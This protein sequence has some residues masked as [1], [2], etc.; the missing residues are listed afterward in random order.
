MKITES[1]RKS[2]LV[3]Q[4]FNLFDSG[5]YQP[6]LE[7]FKIIDSIDSE[8]AF[9]PIRMAF[10]YT[11]LGNYAEAQGKLMEAI[12][13]NPDNLSLRAFLA[14][15]YLDQ[16]MVDKALETLNPLV[17]NGKPPKLVSDSYGLCL[18]RM[19]K[20]DEGYK[21]L[22]LHTA[23]IGY[24]GVASR[25]FSACELYLSEHPDISIEL[26][27]NLSDEISRNLSIKFKAKINDLLFG[28]KSLFIS[29]AEKNAREIL[30]LARQSVNLGEYSKARQY[31]EDLLK[32]K[33]NNDL[34]ALAAETLSGIKDYAGVIGVADSI[35]GY[36]NYREINTLKT[37]SLLR[38][39]DLKGAEALLG[40]SERIEISYLYGLLYLKQGLLH[41][42]RKKFEKVLGSMNINTG[43][44]LAGIRLKEA[45]RVYNLINDNRLYQ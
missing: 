39:G 16:G 25:V 34:L 3:R 17:S 38:L 14:T 41:S 2:I 43:M 29:G 13:L 7:K 35:D 8:D 15:N 20:I 18:L 21:A 44:D 31:I 40:N 9:S 19:G 4:A 10:C 23:H 27:E 42:A 5:E 45:L 33:P 28:I 26:E 30:S 36:K 1:I 24:W 11:E 22:T 12:S 32:I 37:L 6:A